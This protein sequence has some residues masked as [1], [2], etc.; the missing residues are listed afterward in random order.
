[1]RP[2]NYGP[3]EECNGWGRIT[4]P[5]GDTMEFWI[6]VRDGRVER[7]GFVT[8]GCGSSRA[9][10]SMTTTLAEGQSVEDAA[11][12]RQ[13]DVLTALG[14]DFPEEHCALLAVNT[15]KAACEAHRRRRDG[16]AGGNGLSAP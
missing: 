13:Q 3:L 1:M 16:E 5:C 8:D 15:L 7:V 12:L 10:G 9:C 2:R 14:D 6:V 4:G 11:A